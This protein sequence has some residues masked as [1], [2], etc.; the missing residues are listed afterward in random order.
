M[1]LLFYTV[2]FVSIF[3][4]WHCVWAWT[5]MWE[6]SNL[7][8]PRMRLF[9]FIGGGGGGGGRGGGEAAQ[10]LSIY[11]HEKT[12]QNKLG[13]RLSTSRACSPQPKWLTEL[14]HL[15]S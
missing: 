8:I 2:G 1:A 5:R 11:K 12:R 9:F 6:S 4:C 13:L 7:M 15:L 14:V 3:S 10:P